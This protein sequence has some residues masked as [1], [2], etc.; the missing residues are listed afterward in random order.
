MK[1]IF[2]AKSQ[3]SKTCHYLNSGRNLI[4]SVYKFYSLTG[5]YVGMS[6]RA[7]L[8][9]AGKRF[10]ISIIN[11]HFIPDRGITR[12]WIQ[13]RQINHHENSKQEL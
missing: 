12:I 8:L 9:T 10:I 4:L 2:L 6:L 11:Q 7:N 3:D 13:A 1:R 5:K